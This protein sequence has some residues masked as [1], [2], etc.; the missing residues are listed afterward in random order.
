MPPGECLEVPGGLGH[1]VHFVVNARKKRDPQTFLLHDTASDETTSVGTASVD[2]IAAGISRDLSE[3]AAVLK[4]RRMVRS[5]AALSSNRIQDKICSKNAGGAFHSAEI[6]R[7][8]PPFAS[9]WK[10]RSSH[11]RDP[12]G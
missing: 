5:T 7:S 8:A 6:G 2:M 4:T 3:T 10:I 1:A 9:G 12:I 11:R